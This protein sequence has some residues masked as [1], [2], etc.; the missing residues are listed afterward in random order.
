M[1][2][3]D[4]VGVIYL[5]KVFCRRTRE[6]V[7]YKV[8]NTN[9]YR[10]IL[11]FSFLLIVLFGSRQFIFRKILQ[12]LVNVVQSCQLSFPSGAQGRAVICY[13]LVDVMTTIGLRIGREMA[14]EHM[15][16]TLQ[17]FFVCFE[18]V[19]GDRSPGAKPCPGK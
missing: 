2:Y 10:Q 13:K 11:C 14:R 18:L 16:G 12:P 19:H 4:Y 15:T 3:I 17:H 8:H 7:E 1:P 6:S 5:I 9:V